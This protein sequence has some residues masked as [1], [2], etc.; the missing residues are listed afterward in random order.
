M[1]PNEDAVLRALQNAQEPLSAR[2]VAAHAQ[3]T[4]K[5]GKAALASLVGSRKVAELKDSKPFRYRVR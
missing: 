1:T 2:S 3:V 5:D 4:L